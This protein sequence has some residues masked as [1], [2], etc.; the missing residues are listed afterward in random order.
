MKMIDNEIRKV[1]KGIGWHHGELV[2]ARLTGDKQMVLYCEKEIK[3]GHK[4]LGH[5]L[6]INRHPN[7]GR[8]RLNGQTV[9]PSGIGVDRVP[10]KA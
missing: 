1:S 9:K 7:S 8:A 2:L 4:M 10:T 5:L 3:A 6:H